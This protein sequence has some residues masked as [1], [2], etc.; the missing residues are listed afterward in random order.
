[1]VGV[2][3]KIAATL[4]GNQYAD[5]G[6]RLASITINLIVLFFAGKILRRRFRN[7][8]HLLLILETPTALFFMGVVNPSGWEI[9]TGI[10][11]SV[12]LADYLFN[13]PKKDDSANSWANDNWVQSNI[14]LP[15][16][17]SSLLFCSARPISWIWM[18]VLIAFSATIISKSTI[19]KL[20]KKLILSVIPGVIMALAW[21]LTH[22]TFMPTLP[23]YTPLKGGVAHTVKLFATSV[24]DFPNRLQQLVGNLG[25]LDTSTLP[26][27]FLLFILTWAIALSRLTSEAKFSR[28]TILTGLIAVVI[29]PSGIETYYA[30]RWPGWWSGRYT[31]PLLVGILILLILKTERNHAKRFNFLLGSALLINGVMG[32]ENTSRYS[33]GV[34]NY[35]P[36]RYSHPS[37][38]TLNFFTCLVI[39]LSYFIFGGVVLTRELIGNKTS[40]N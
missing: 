24:G 12:S 34:N 13:S 33:F 32:I 37:I 9:S 7:F 11:F 3:Q 18:L 2:G 10:L 29:I 4:A 39:F 15:L 5:I 14:S 22:G 35:F 17:V 8:S 26:L 31:L 16:L 6:G 19:K 30:R 36:I 38:G 1:M 23:G 25:W 27:I 21:D 40:Y 28:L 20:G